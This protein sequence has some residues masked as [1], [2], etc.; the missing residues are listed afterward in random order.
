[1]RAKSEGK[2][3]G[4]PVAV[5]TTKNVQ[6]MRQQGMT[7]MQVSGKLA[8][9]TAT[10]KRHWNLPAI[11]YRGGKCTTLREGKGCMAPKHVCSAIR[12]LEF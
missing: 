3:L 11:P 8:I 12:K 4:R 5:N 9:G 7:Q 2:K 10:V 6:R 1:M